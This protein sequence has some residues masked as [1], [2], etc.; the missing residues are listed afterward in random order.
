MISNDVVTSRKV[1]D[2]LDIADANPDN[3][4]ACALDISDRSQIDNVI[5]HVEKR[6]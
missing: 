4:L 2:V 6:A 3:S 5:K 1:P